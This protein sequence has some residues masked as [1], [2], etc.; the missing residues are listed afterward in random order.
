[1]EWRAG[2]NLISSIRRGRATLDLTTSKLSSGHGAFARLLFKH[3][4]Y[5]TAHTSRQSPILSICN[6]SNII[7]IQ[8]G[9]PPSLQA[10]ELKQSSFSK[11]FPICNL[12]DMQMDHPE[13]IGLPE[14][15]TLGRKMDG[16]SRHVG[17]VIPLL[18]SDNVSCIPSSLSLPRLIS[19]HKA[20]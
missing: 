11:H 15:A 16:W 7:P 20:L 10:L 9:R 19:K 14:M 12:V 17:M 13:S 3:I 18:H 1:V 8:Q 4:G 5:E 2:P 6:I